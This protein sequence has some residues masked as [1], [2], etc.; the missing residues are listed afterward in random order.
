VRVR[1]PHR[2]KRYGATVVSPRSG[3]RA[4]EEYWDAVW[5]AAAQTGRPS[6]ATPG[7]RNHVDRAFAAMFRAILPGEDFEL[8][9]VG[10]A[11]SQWLAYFAAVHGARVCGLDY[12]ERGCEI[13]RAILREAGVDGEVVHGDLFE[14]SAALTSRFDVVVSF[15]VVEHFDDTAGAI[16][17]LRQYVKPGGLVVTVVPNMIGAVGAIERCINRPVYDLHVGL[18]PQDLAAAHA[19]AGMTVTGAGYFLSTNFGVLNTNGLDP[20]ARATRAK[21]ALC[22]N[23][24]RVSKAVWALEARSRPLRATRLFAPYVVV[25]ARR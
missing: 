1:R 16:A 15:G 7:F 13:E 21:R 8:L 2:V 3:D 17:A 5:A 9:E 22:V 12:S 24:G 4:G 23:L 14:P 11:H 19:S 6:P 20:E 25:T 10:C 18:A